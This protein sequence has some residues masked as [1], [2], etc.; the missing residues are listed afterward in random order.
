M[1]EPCWE[2]L[3]ELDVY[4]DGECGP[5]FE[6]AVR[7][8]LDACSPCLDRADF[9]RELR[10]LIAAKCKDAAPSGLLDRVIDSLTKR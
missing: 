2:V 3:A 6:E 8:H 1:T 10:A 5:S 9:Q 7:R 4:L